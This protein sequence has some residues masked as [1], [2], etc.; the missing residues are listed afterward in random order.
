MNPLFLFSL[1]FGATY[2]ELEDFRKRVSTGGDLAAEANPVTLR[3]RDLKVGHCSIH[4]EDGSA[5]PIKAGHGEHEYTAGYLFQGEGTLTV[6]FEERADAWNFA[7]HMVMTARHD[8]ERMAPIAHQEESYRVS[9][10][11]GI[12]ISTRDDALRLLLPEPEEGDEVITDL[13][14]TADFTIVIEDRRDRVVR[15]IAAGATVPNRLSQMQFGGMDLRPRI[16]DELLQRSWGGIDQ[17]QRL[18]FADFITDD[19]FNVAA[20]GYRRQTSVRSEDRWMSCLE[21]PAGVFDRGEASQVFIHGREGSGAYHRLRVTGQGFPE[22]DREFKDVPGVR[23]RDLVPVKAELDIDAEP[24]KMRKHIRF[25]IDSTITVRATRDGVQRMALS[26]PVGQSQART[27]ELD[28]LTD[29]EGN[30]PPWASLG[31]KNFS[32]ISADG[33]L[34][35]V[36]MVGSA[37]DAAAEADIPDT[38]G[39]GGGGG[40]DAP[41]LTA[42]D[43]SSEF[44]VQQNPEVRKLNPDRDWQR[45]DLLVLLPEPLQQGEEFVF[46]LDWSGE[47]SQIRAEDDPST[48][49][50]I[51]IGQPTTGF[52]DILPEF[53]P[54]GN[55]TRWTYTATVTI[56]ELTGFDA[57]VSG[58]ASRSWRDQ[59][60]ETLTWLVRGNDLVRPGIAFGKWNSHEEMVIGFPAMQIHLHPVESYAL[61]E[62]GPQLRTVLQ[63]YSKLMPP[64]REKEWDIYTGPLKSGHW[65]GGAAGDTMLELNR[66]SDSSAVVRNLDPYS[67]HTIL[68]REVGRKYWNGLVMPGG[69]RDAWIATIMP[70]VYAAFYIRAVFGTQDYFAWMEKV[71]IVIEG[72]KGASSIS[73]GDDE[74]RPPVDLMGNYTGSRMGRHF[75]GMYIIG[76]SLRYMVGEELY[77]SSL[78]ALLQKRK[79]KY[80]TTQLIQD[81]FEKTSGQ[82]LSDFFDFWVRGGRI[83]EITLTTNTVDGVTRGCIEADVPFGNFQLPVSIIDHDG[84]RVSAAL[85]DVIDGQGSFEVPDRK[86]EVSVEVDP[87]GLVPLRTRKVKE[88]DE[89]SCF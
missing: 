43:Y 45:F 83:P 74:L 76:N 16:S 61:E 18:L 68:A 48:G 70:E 30:D 78:D 72:S 20:G 17:D 2:P 29:S 14:L 71:R 3:N 28:A 81:T 7:N 15:A 84:F 1:A 38:V 80:V 59:D 39:L 64:L 75:Y 40:S 89:L 25:D 31:S 26:M 22:E 37:D 63:F 47:W 79:G 36:S 13:A 24:I 35:G 55:P 60:K 46:H 32:E 11:R 21:D 41:T 85:V 9:I 87:D 54:V 82:D 5:L 4:F 57:A 12:V 52:R 34:D 27:F 58:M 8:E 69:K 56:P 77:Y 44:S 10:G 49:E 67:D 33:G 23:K 50:I 88:E 53:Y 6:D 51:R 62:F 86:G 19:S 66:Y 65:W 42:T 73:G